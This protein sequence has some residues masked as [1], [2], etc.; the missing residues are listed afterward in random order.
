LVITSPIAAPV[1]TGAGPADRFVQVSANLVLNPD[2][3]NYTHT[4]NLANLTDPFSSLDATWQPYYDAF[5]DISGITDTPI[6]APSIIK[7]SVT[8]QI[9]L[10]Q[11]M[12]FSN[13]E[14][15]NGVSQSWWRLPIGNISPADTVRMNIWRADSSQGNVSAI[16]LSG[17]S[18]TDPSTV[19]LIWSQT[20]DLS[21][22]TP[23][24]F[25]Y[26][27]L[28]V[29]VTPDLAGGVHV[30]NLSSTIHA[31]ETML[32]TPDTNRGDPPF[33]GFNIVGPSSHAI[34]NYSV[35]SIPE[36]SFVLSANFSVE[37]SAENPPPDY[38]SAFLLQL[39][40]E[41]EPVQADTVT[42]N[43]DPGATPGTTVTN[44]TIPVP[45]GPN[46]CDPPVLY[47]VDLTPQSCNGRISFDVTDILK[48]DVAQ[49]VANGLVMT[50][51][52]SLV[53]YP[54]FAPS[55]DV[56]TD[57]PWPSRVVPWLTVE[58]ARPQIFYN[59]SY[60]AA[61][62]PIVPNT[63]Y[64]V[65]YTVQRPSSSPHEYQLYWTSG[66]MGNDGQYDSWYRFD[67]M[68]QAAFVP[69]DLDSSVV[70]TRGMSNG[71][72]GLSG[73]CET[74]LDSAQFPGMNCGANPAPAGFTQQATRVKYKQAFAD[75]LVDNSTHI[76]M[77]LPLVGTQ[78]ANPVF[79][80]Y[81]DLEFTIFY[82]EG[83]SDVG[84]VV[85][86]QPDACTLGPDLYVPST[87]TYYVHWLSDLAT[88]RTLGCLQWRDKANMLWMSLPLY[89]AISGYPF[90]NSGKHISAVN[91]DLYQYEY[92]PVWAG[93]SPGDFL[94][95]WFYIQA[96]PVPNANTSVTMTT[97]GY[98]TLTYTLAFALY[99]YFSVDGFRIENTNR[100]IILIPIEEPSSPLGK[101]Q[102][103]QW[104]RGVVALEN[105][106]VDFIFTG[107]GLTTRGT[108]TNIVNGNAC[109]GQALLNGAVGVIHTTF[110]RLQELLWPLIQFLLDLGA[111]IAAAER[112]FIEA[113]QWFLFIASQVI[114]IFL[115]VVTFA[116]AL[117]SPMYLG[118]AIYEW[119]RNGYDVAVLKLIMA[120]G[121]N[122]V[123]V[124]L[125]LLAS[126]TLMCISIL[127][128]VASIVKGVF[129]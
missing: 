75:V 102:A 128:A 37:Q 88:G 16:T 91:F 110:E 90:S 65:E 7:R 92:G 67:T 63:D 121:W 82:Q 99:G 31:T 76:N 28:C 86:S 43:S 11:R 70:M 18:F 126:F 21:L 113:T 118:R 78:I 42:W 89:S 14:V 69:V 15:L 61:Y 4:V 35:D 41:S 111:G 47:Y 83:G 8:D 66:D 27:R 55:Q 107:L 12:H 54:F 13:V 117:L 46:L 112:F 93:W 104:W 125:G 48:T 23:A 85:S 116:I 30:A 103:Y 72:A 122:K 9:D 19:H 53:A 100:P 1:V 80:L 25:L 127:S 2:R 3:S 57:P 52:S 109:I 105:C 115:I 94:P 45:P 17:I 96:Q 101:L 68:P 20:I 29:P 60:M 98:G 50:S 22:G 40:R 33:G 38:A 32:T 58:W 6:L 62:A 79:Y 84:Q 123:S 108:L 120:D 97:V 51:N 39:S 44:L 129:F 24:P 64:F 106:P 114:S 81:F 95:N 119:V 56:V 87:S 34:W 36:C 5:R 49:R 77:F 74:L 26:R 73:Y 71:I 10:V 59:F 124:L